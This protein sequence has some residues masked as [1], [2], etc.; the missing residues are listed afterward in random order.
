MRVYGRIV[1]LVIIGLI[2]VGCRDRDEKR[3]PRL[4]PPQ[5]ATGVGT[6]QGEEAPPLV[7][8]DLHGNTIRLSTYRGKVVLLDFWRHD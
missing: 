2:L 5:P 6:E 8:E 1:G 7:G 3:S 4:S